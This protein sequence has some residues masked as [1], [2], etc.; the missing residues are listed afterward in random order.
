MCG[1]HYNRS[2][3]VGDPGPSGRL[4]RPFQ[5]RCEVPSCRNPHRAH[6][7]CEPHY[8]SFQ[9]YGDPHEVARRRKAAKLTCAAPGCDRPTRSK[10]LVDRGGGPALCGLHFQRMRKHGQLDLPKREARITKGYINSQGYRIV[11]FNGR[12][13]QEHRL[14]LER[15]IG[16]EL[17]AEE[18]V[19]HKN[20]V[21][22][23]NRLENL[24]LWS[25]WQPPGQRV[26][27]KVAWA[28][29][30]IDRYGS[31]VDEGVIT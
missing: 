12:V 25:G 28:R 23:D 26:T 4:R 13:V 8:D 14:V 1:L 31:L 3:A 21:R 24:E 22:H 27:D 18:T 7:Y 2:Y 9:K 11:S 30:I 10:G 15:A 19:H 6:G 20:G 17:T 16:R 5:K 29:Q